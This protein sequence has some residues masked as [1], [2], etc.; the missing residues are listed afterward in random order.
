MTAPSPE[1]P[2]SFRIRS[3][4]AGR[5]VPSWAW[6][7]LAIALAVTLGAALWLEGAHLDPT[8]RDQVHDLSLAIRIREGRALSDGNRHPLFPALLAPFAG[9]DPAFQ[10]RALMVGVGVGVLSLLAVYVAAAK[11][12]SRRLGVVAVL[13]LLIEFRLQGRRIC[14]E[15]LAAGLLAVGVALLAWAR[16][17]P[18]P[19]RWTF[20]G[21]AVLGLAWLTKGSATLALG[22]AALWTITSGGARARRLGLLCAG[23][24]VA[25]WPLMAWNV[26]QGHGPLYNVNSAHVM[27]EDGWDGDLD[28]RTIATPATWWAGHSMREGVSRWATGLVTQRGIEFVYGTFLVLGAL[29]LLERRRRRRAAKAGDAMTASPSFE[30]TAEARRGWASLALW[31]GAIWLLAFAWYAPIVSSRRLLFPIFAVLVPPVLAALA[32][33]GRAVGRTW[34]PSSIRRLGAVRSRAFVLVLTATVALSGYAFGLLCL[35]GG[36]SSR[37]AIDPIW[38]EAADAMRRFCPKGSRVLVRPSR[39]YPPDWLLEGQVEYVELP[40]AV[41]DADVDPWTRRHADFTLDNPGLRAQRPNGGRSEWSD[42]RPTLVLWSFD[43]SARVRLLRSLV[44]PSPK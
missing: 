30:S 25:A 19:L 8:A 35:A 10:T 27:W 42:V 43:S 3:F 44:L 14:P 26:S 9:R 6:D 5:A 18:K 39:T 20:A 1:M 4:V 31:N 23:F 7:A 38:I 29:A 15:P 17:G 16:A 41:A 12:F 36:P 13:A 22:A 33:W 37:V 24:V 28:K 2:P 11:V 40:A 32:E 34:V 21:G